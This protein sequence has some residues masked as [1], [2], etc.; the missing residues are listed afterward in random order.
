M[1]NILSFLLLCMPFTVCSQM[2]WINVDSTYQPLPSSVHVFFS[3]DSIDGKPNRCYYIIAPLKDKSLLFSIDTGYEKRYTPNQYYE[4]N[5]H[6]LLVVNCTF[7]EFTHNRNLNLVV[8]NN[9]VVAYNNQS[10]AG[11]GKDT[12]TYNHVFSSALGISKHRKADIV[13]T[14]ADSSLPYAYASQH[15]YPA[16]RDSIEKHS[17]DA[18]N[19][20]YSKK[21]STN[22]DFKKWNIE[23]AFGGGPVLLQNGAIQITNNEE[24]KFAGKAI[25]DKHPRTAVGYTENNEI[26]VLV[27]EGRFPGKAEGATLT[28]EA[29]ILQQLN[30]VEAM[31]LDGGGSSCMLINGK[32][33]ITPS[34]K[35][36][37]RPIPAAFIIRHH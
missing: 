15:S 32:Q 30:C 25:A 35:E 20:I 14:Y 10:L 27:I 6:P 36:G 4:R 5:D 34:D 18:L 16:I 7:F 8:Q 22:I 31:N 13:W 23:T 2:K 28:D 24:Q 19:K 12:F 1:K 21:L 9:K 11:R 3:N 17:L 33:T 26:I 37:Q 29:K